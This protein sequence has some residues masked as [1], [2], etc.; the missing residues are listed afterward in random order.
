MNINHNYDSWAFLSS[1]SSFYIYFWTLL[2][3]SSLFAWNVTSQLFF[4]NTSNYFL[5][6]F[7]RDS[8]IFVY[9]NSNSN[10]WHFWN[11]F[12]R[13]GKASLISSSLRGLFDNPTQILVKFFLSII[14]KSFCIPCFWTSLNPKLSTK[15]FKY[16]NFSI[17]LTIVS[18]PSSS[19]KFSWRCSS[20]YWS[21]GIS[22]N[23]SSK[24]LAALVPI[25]FTP[26]LKFKNLSFFR[27][28]IP[29]MMW[30]YPLY[31]KFFVLTPISRN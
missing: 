28:F 19:M 27:F 22:N 6:K 30:W 24:V 5:M 29:L 26:H 11:T 23:N 21:Y 2:T 4:S 13:E 7:M 17:A 18:N 31:P 12:W 20:R 1:S 14:S 16:S 15:D 25:R 10:F 9:K 3:S 8:L